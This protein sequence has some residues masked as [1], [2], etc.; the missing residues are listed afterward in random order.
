[1][2]MF[3]RQLRGPNGSYLKLQSSVLEIEKK[4]EIHILTF[5]HSKWKSRRT[6]KKNAGKM[7]VDHLQC[8]GNEI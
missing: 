7:S 6:E 5:I 2:E 3:R 4:N 1:M 8:N